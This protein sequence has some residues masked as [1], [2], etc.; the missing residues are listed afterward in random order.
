[1]PFTIINLLTQW[2]R[3][4]YGLRFAPALAIFLHDALRMLVLGCWPVH[5][6]WKLR[7]NLGTKWLRVNVTGHKRQSRDEIDGRRRL[8]GL[9]RVTFL[10]L[11]SPS[12]PK[13][14]AVSEYLCTFYHNITWDTTWRAECKEQLVIV[15]EML[16]FFKGLEKLSATILSDHHLFCRMHERERGY[17]PFFPYHHH[18]HA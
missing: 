2:G 7:T 18:H 13:L 14:A 8:N 4:A 10:L 12:L 3:D 16:K 9:T 11:F 15:R 1:M 17:L 5:W 6:R